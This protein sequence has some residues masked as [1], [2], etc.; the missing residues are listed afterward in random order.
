MQNHHRLPHGTFDGMDKEEEV[1]P[2]KSHKLKGWQLKI[3]ILG[4]QRSVY[5]IYIYIYIQHKVCTGLFAKIKKFVLGWSVEP[6]KLKSWTHGF[7]CYQ[8]EN[9]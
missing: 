8:E 9:F 1:L 5:T 2:M 4:S 6:L 3:D 7:K